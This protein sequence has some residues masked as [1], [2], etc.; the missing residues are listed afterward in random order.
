MKPPRS[1]SLR[2]KF[3]LIVFGGAVLPLALLGLWLTRTAERSGEEL[4]RARLQTSLSQV[5]DEV[6]LRWLSQRSQL[7]RLAECPAVQS[8]LR[9]SVT[10][11]E[12]ENAALAE[13]RTLYA[14]VDDAVGSAEIVDLSE[15]VRWIVGDDGSAGAR[16]GLQGEATLTVRLGIFDAGT[17][18]RLGNLDA[19]VLMS[20]LL[21]GGAGWGGVSGSV[22]AV[23]DR[24]SGASLIPLSI[25]PALFARESFVWG[26]EPWLTVR[27]VLH[28]PP[29][30]LVLAAP[31]T[32]FA[33]PFQEAARRNLWILA[34]VALGGFTLATLLTQRTTRA[35]V[36]LAAAAEAVSRG[37]LDRRV[38]AKSSDEVGR[39]ARAFN[40]MTESLRHTLR[41]LSQ[42]QALAAVGEFAASLAHEVRNPLTSIRLDL[43]RVE[44][45]L[46]DESDA[47][48]LLGRAL[49][50]IERVDHSVTGA[51]RVARSGRITHEPVDVRQPLEA[52]LHSA[53][54][55]FNAREA[56]LEPAQL[57]EQPISVRGEAAALEQLFLNLLLNAAQALDPGE[58]A[59]V[60]LKADAGE[61][62]ISIWDS[63]SGIAPEELEKVFKPFYSTRPEGTGLGLAIAQRIA[64][65]HGGDLSIESTP[66]SGTTVRVRLP[67]GASA[68]T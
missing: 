27:H 5:I 11:P 22:L 63:G 65:A 59:G 34:I 64:V 58:R 42:R 49:S 55:E 16:G 19:R 51:L 10:D 25:D 60:E 36:R 66:G 8:A 44:E 24:N 43:Q 33:E 4:L 50:E 12:A 41:E 32:P 53:E 48:D 57:G 45:K 26:E 37:D 21:P 2:S 15:T 29:M 9:D 40:A 47:R 3:I 67:L 38:E 18:A 31:V 7:L 6:G 23:F 14:G 62:L 68:T 1:L 52:A 28:E 17:G 30:D 46:P 54:P 61:A 35:L 20:G 56:R 39:V 13:L